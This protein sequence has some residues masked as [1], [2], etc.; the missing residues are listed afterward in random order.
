MRRYAH[1]LNCIGIMDNS[2]LFQY[3]I[4]SVALTLAPGPDNL[5]VLSQG[6]AHG[7]RQ[8]IITA[9]GMCSGIS[10][11][12]TAAAVGLAAVLYSS[13]ILFSVITYCGAGYLLFIAWK[14][15]RS[16]SVAEPGETVERSGRELFSRG[17]L[18][19]VLN[20]KVG[21]FFVAFMPQFVS[22]S[23]QQPVMLQMIILGIVFM[24]QAIV[25]FTTIGYCSGSIGNLLVQHPRYARM[26][27]LFSAMV[28]VLLAGRLLITG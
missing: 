19:N 12:T 9:L 8:A 14:T 6:V 10:V 27:S 11:H 21:M 2:T 23:G 17:F 4:A 1:G 24:L 18:M 7:R 5:F 22:R 25:I 15:L 26:L 16:S 13:P 3:L 20:P 28:L